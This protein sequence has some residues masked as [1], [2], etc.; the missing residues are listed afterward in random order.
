[1]I[2]SQQLEFWECEDCSDK[3]DFLPEVCECGGTD[4]VGVDW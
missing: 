3:F 4:F 2:M 1:M